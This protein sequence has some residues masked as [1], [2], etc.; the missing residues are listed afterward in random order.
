LAGVRLARRRM[1]FTSAKAERDLGFR[2]RPYVEALY[3]AVQWF[4]DAGYLARGPERPAAHLA[5]AGTKPA[6]S[7]QAAS[8]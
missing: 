8:D 5:G 4:H 2:A 3:D 1:F 6:S 7:V